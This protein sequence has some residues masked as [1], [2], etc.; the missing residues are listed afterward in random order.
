MKEVYIIRHAESISNAGEKTENQNTVPLS[1]KGKIQ[2]KE[3]AE[4]LNVIPELIVVSQYSRTTETAMPFIEKHPSIPIETWDV[5]EFIYLDPKIYSGTT[6]EQRFES[7]KKYWNE[8]SVHYKEADGSESFSEM[9]KRIAKLINDLKERPEK[10]ITIFSHARFIQAIKLYIEK[11]KELGRYNLTDEELNELKEI[12]RE[13][14]VG[15]KKFPI[16]NASV[17]KIEI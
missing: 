10:I 13:E 4:R 8:A 2:A 11:V 3:L 6:A 16:E 14:I 1:E 15:R 12:H 17:H 7:V 9:T 5:H